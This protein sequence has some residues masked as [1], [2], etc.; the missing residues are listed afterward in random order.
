MPRIRSLTSL[1][2]LI[3]GLA[4]AV[5][6]PAQP[7][8]AAGPQYKIDVLHSRLCVTV[9]NGS[10]MGSS[11]M[12]WNCDGFA[13][14]RWTFDFVG[15]YAKIRNVGSGMCLTVYN[16]SGPGAAVMQWNCDGFDNG[17]W[18]GRF[19]NHSNGHDWY[20]LINKATGWCLTIDS[21]GLSLGTP[22]V[23]GSCSPSASNNRFTWY[24]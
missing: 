20:D 22:T 7:A 15:D 13:N 23:L 12:Q 2:V 9:Y 14:G 3:A 6:L 8:L 24:T 10:P 16:G 21:Y 11:A 19:I 4:A 18:F 1:L 17:L 5:A